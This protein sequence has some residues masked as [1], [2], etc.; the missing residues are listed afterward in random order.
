MYFQHNNNKNIKTFIEEFL[1]RRVKPL[2][3]N[4]ARVYQVRLIQQKTLDVKW[5][6]NS[7]ALNIDCILIFLILINDDKLF[8]PQ[9][10][11]STFSLLFRLKKARGTFG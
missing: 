3:Q 2:N 10:L 4:I 11:T 8:S 7:A 9:I 6:F 1:A 5:P